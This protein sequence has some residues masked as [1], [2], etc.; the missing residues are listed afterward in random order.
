VG[1]RI[2]RPADFSVH[3]VVDNGSRKESA[4]KPVI[5]A[6]PASANLDQVVKTSEMRWRAGHRIFLEEPA[7]L[8]PLER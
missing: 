5:S 6:N 2:T 8:Q 1:A 3:F 7:F 4:S